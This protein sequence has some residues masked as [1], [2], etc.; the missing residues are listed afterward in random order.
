MLARLC[1]ALAA[2]STV[3]FASALSSAQARIDVPSGCGSEG[4]LRA[5]LARLLGAQRAADAAP[6]RLSI[7]QTDAG[8]YALVLELAGESR[9][10]RDPDCRALFNAAVIVAAV[11][12]DPSVQ[13]IEP[14]PAVEP[15][16]A[17]VE[18][19]LASKPAPAPAPEVPKPAA[20]APERSDPPRKSPPVRGEI[21]IGGGAVIALLPALAP[22]LELSGALAYGD[23]GLALA[24]RYLAPT[25]ESAGA[26]H[27]VEVR[28]LGAR[29]AAFYDVARIVRFSAGVAAD[30]LDGRGL[31]SAVRGSSE[32]GTALA[33]VAEAA[34]TPV[35]VEPLFIS[36]AISGH[37]ALVRPSFEI[38]GYGGVF[39]VPPVG[40][41]GV[42]RLGWEF[43]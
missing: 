8:D 15:T 29:L 21:T 26:T 24:A 23:L 27:A 11:T 42:M 31:G 22:S 6:E 20:P 43:R 30:R 17:A 28:G 32:A 33:V 18:P 3:L 7:V 34:A 4:E 2:C 38:A 5:G 37:Y 19:T 14:L 35:R 40:G 16:P 12:I 10:L 36:V 39:R 9:S 41:S 25:E 13:V 1:C